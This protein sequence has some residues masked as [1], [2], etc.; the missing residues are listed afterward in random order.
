M[1]NYLVNLFYS[2]IAVHDGVSSS[3]NSNHHSGKF[4]I[5]TA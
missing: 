5:P 1:V 4:D 2:S 3:K